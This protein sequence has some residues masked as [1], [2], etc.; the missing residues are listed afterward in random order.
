MKKFP[1][2]LLLFG[3]YPVLALWAQNIQEVGFD[4]IVRVVVASLLV[5]VLVWLVLWLIFRDAERAGLIAAVM[6]VIFFS[7]G[8]L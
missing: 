7:Y 3:L 6:L 8:H 5:C 4:Q 1:V 2:Y